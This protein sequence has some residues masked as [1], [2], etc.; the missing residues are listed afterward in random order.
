MLKKLIKKIFLEK[1]ILGAD[2]SS[3]PFDKVAELYGAKGFKVKKISEV[4]EAV[5]SCTS[6]AI[7]Q[8]S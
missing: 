3:P 7:S 1:D 2:I 6:N 4:S 5:K 8:L